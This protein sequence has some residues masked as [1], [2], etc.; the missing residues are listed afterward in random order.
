MPWFY[1]RR[2]GDHA[3]VEGAD[4]SHLV[5]SLRARKG[6]QIEVI[7]QAASA[8]LVVRLESVSPERVEGAILAERP[9]QAEPR[10]RV[11]LAIANLPAPALELL[12]SR[13]TEA[14][15]FAFHILQA[16]EGSQGINLC[17]SPPRKA[18]RA[19]RS[20]ARP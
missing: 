16:G 2:E 1:A 8:F 19:R 15:A 9:H 20:A 6:E 13:C 17:E 5:R 14:G 7:D 3:V 11:T 10:A 4:A 18:L 12:F